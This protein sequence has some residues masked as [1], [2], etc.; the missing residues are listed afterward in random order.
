M[1]AGNLRARR[2]ATIIYRTFA[3]ASLS[4]TF[5]SSNSYAQPPHHR[6]PAVHAPP[7]PLRGVSRNNASGSAWAVRSPHQN[8]PGSGLADRDRF[9]SRF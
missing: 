8:V 2:V 5:C 7:I 6:R 3:L 9:M 1:S 4:V